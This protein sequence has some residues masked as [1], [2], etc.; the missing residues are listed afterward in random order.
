MKSLAAFF[1]SSSCPRAIASA[2]IAL[3]AADCSADSTRFG[4]ANTHGSE[5]TGSLASSGAAPVG[6]VEARPLPQTS[7]V[8]PQAPSHVAQ[9]S[10][11]PVVAGGGRGT[12]SYSPQAYESAGAS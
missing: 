1:H 10:P 11:P 5:S 12:A 8:P 7:S 4:D 6:R 9:A 2:L 3:G